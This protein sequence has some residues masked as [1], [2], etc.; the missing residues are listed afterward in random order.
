MIRLVGGSG[1]RVRVKEKRL[2]V[3]TPLPLPFVLES[4][5]VNIEGVGVPVKCVRVTERDVE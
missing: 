5:A 4:G 1:G 2:L 3:F